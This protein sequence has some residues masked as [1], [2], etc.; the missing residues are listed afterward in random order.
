MWGFTDDGP[1]GNRGRVS[2]IG[3]ITTVRKVLAGS[4]ECSQEGLVACDIHRAR[5]YGVCVCVGG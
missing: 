4:H 3:E 2:G 1:T 5:W